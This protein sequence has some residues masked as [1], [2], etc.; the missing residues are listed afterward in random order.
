MA[1]TS[2]KP[3]NPSGLSVENSAQSAPEATISASFEHVVKAKDMRVDAGS[4]HQEARADTNVA[5]VEMWFC[6]V[7]GVVCMYCGIAGIWA[8]HSHGLLSIHFARLGSAYVPVL[9]ATAI[10]CLIL[11]AILIR[12]GWAQ[13]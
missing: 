9:R 1:A 3:A 7:L 6:F 12:H 8:S 10:A 13:S 11:G 5:V 4:S 2:R